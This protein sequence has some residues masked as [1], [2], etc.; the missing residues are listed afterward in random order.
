MTCGA[1]VYSQEP[2]AMV[3]AT[4]SNAAPPLDAVARLARLRKLAWFLDAQFGLPG[5]RFRFGIN[6]LVGLA[7]AM[8][9]VVMGIVSLYI[10]NEARR[11]GVPGPLLGRMLMNVAVEVVGGAVPLLGDLFDMVFK[12]NLRNIA[13][14]EEWV[15]RR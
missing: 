15:A 9:D 11:M 13:L 1:I 7:P 2:A 10:V 8:G 14:L 12:A 4:F 5:T 3:A 6:S